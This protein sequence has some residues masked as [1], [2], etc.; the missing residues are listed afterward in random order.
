MKG[1]ISSVDL[2]PA[3]LVRKAQRAPG[4][5]Q[6]DL[7]AQVSCPRVYRWEQPRDARWSSDAGSGGEALRAQCVAY[8]FGIKRN[9]LRMLWEVGFDVTV[10][11]GSFSADDALAL[12]PDAVFLSNG[13]GDP[14][15]PI[16][17]SRAVRGLIGRVPIFGICL[18]HQ[19]LALALGAKT[20]K[21]KFGHRGANHPVKDLRTGKVAVTSQ[22]HGYAVDPDTLPDGVQ[23][24]HVN[25]NDSTLEGFAFPEAR[26]VAVQYHPESSPGPHDSHRMF[27]EFHE[28]VTGEQPTQTTQPPANRGDRL[29]G[30]ADSLASGR[31]REAAASWQGSEALTA[32]VPG[33]APR[34]RSLLDSRPSAD[35]S[36]SVLEGD[37]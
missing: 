35:P 20:F 1:I 22:N 23:L 32:E 34:R 4:L 37:P 29:D 2:D 5:D 14:S 3:S 7:V 25:L 30:R 31:R 16:Y 21:L 10:V 12:E 11:P 26:L 18:G 33:R 19:I 17:A 13:P 27:R 8:D 28:L 9:I 24:T 15:V 36:S 6:Q